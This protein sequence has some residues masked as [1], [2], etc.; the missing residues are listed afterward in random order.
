MKLFSEFQV[1]SMTLKNRIVLAPMG[2]TTDQGNGF[3][4]HDVQ[5]YEER[6]KGGCGLVLTGCVM[7]SDKYEPAACQLLNSNKHVYMLHEMAERVHAH[8]AKFGIQL[9]PG[10]GRM[11]WID[12]FTAP[13]SSS[14]C[15]NYYKPEL[16]CRE[17]PKEGIRHLVE[18]MG[19]SAKLAVAAGV[20]IIEIHAYGGYLIDQFASSKWNKRTDEYGGSFEN[21]QRFLNEIIASVRA[22]VGPDYPIAVKVTVDSVDDDE[23]PIEEG[24]KIIE[25][26][27]KLPIDLIHIGRGAYSCRW[28]MVSSIYQ[29][30][31]FDVEAARMVREAAGDKPIMCHGKLNHKEIAE[32]A[33]VSGAT[34]LVAI[35]HQMTADPHWAN[36]VK[37]GREEDISVCIGCGE[38]HLT[39]MMGRARSCTVNPLCLHENDYK[40]TP[41]DKNKK[42]LV[43]GGGPGGM[44]A[45]AT[46][47]ERGFDVT[48]WEKKNVLGGAMRAAGVPRFKRDILG[49][50][51]YLIHQ[52]DRHGVHVELNKEATL[53]EVKKFGA[54]LVVVATGAD[55]LIIRVPGFERSNVTTAISVLLGEE[56]V[57]NKVVIIGGG[58]VGVETGAELA[59]QG[60]DVTIIELLD[61]LLKV[62]KSFVANEQ[63][64]KYIYKQ[65]GCKDRCSCKLQEIVEDGIIIQNEKG[66]PEKIECD[67]VVFASGSRADHTLYEEIKAA[68]IECRHVGDNISPSKIRT[69]IHD[70]YHYMRVL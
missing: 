70:A 8:G 34:D 31:G 32:D 22:A 56:E 52:L 39:A 59:L 63:N 54:D 14:P 9:S 45:A 49:Q 36:K 43:L 40:L 69:A 25:N 26:L 12:P 23:R 17:M 35:G 1:G 62:K 21:R 55:P 48:L 67:N 61:E 65:S 28:R 19:Y 33:I 3:N 50:N 13:Y 27:S 10:I 42:I 11:N 44:K 66:E 4:E 2:T 57:G 53:E 41:S 37:E 24:M 64:L 16:I 30:D 47:A 60:K 58:E 68:G 20:D 29:T 15:P 7:V 38:C 46:A 6:A 51:D 5:Y 18:A